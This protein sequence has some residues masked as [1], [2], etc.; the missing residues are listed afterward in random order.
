MHEDNEKGQDFELDLSEEDMDPDDVLEISPE[1]TLLSRLDEECEKSNDLLERLQRLQAEFDNYRKRMD[2][3][4][5]E[6]AKFASED[7]LLKV[8]DVYDNILRALEMDFTK[9]PEAA[10]I[11]INAIQQQL[12]KILSMEGVRPIETVGQEFDPYYQHA[13]QRA[14][15]PE[16]PDGVILEEYQKGYMF[17]EKVLRPAVVCVNRHEVP[18]AE[19]DSDEDIDDNSDNDGE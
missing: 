5:S 17:K 14:H 3:R 16:K 2:T 1:D 11:G 12:D 4:F 9:D 10:R 6:V 15:D 8:L 7:I 18:T 19:I 13:A